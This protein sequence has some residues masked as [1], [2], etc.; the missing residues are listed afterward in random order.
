[1]MQVSS[2]GIKLTKES[3]GCKLSAYPDPA[4]GGD[5]W[6][7]GWGSTGPGI[8]KGVTWTQA[9]ADERLVKDLKIISDWIM[10][11]APFTTQNQLD[12]LSD[13]AYNV[14]IGKLSTST[15]WRK[16]IA[17]NPKGAAE[18]FPKWRFASGK[19]IGGLVTRRA[20]EKALYES[21][22]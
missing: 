10:A 20:K 7:I 3:E 6:T 9:Q 1:M 8:K 17:R 5:P 15:L 11:H 14:G 12:A 2:K 21:N 19:V 13:F 16:H 22:V 18:E 4:S